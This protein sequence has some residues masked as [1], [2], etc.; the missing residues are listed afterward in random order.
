VPAAAAAPAAAPAQ[1]KVHLRPVGTCPA[2]QRAKFRVAAAEPFATVVAFLRRQL[3]L[4]P[5]DALFCY[6]HASFAPAPAQRIG[7]LAAAFSSD[8]ELVVHFA[9]QPAYG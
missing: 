8:G 5:G 3:A 1:V 9:L 4:V 2:L 6:L 7:D